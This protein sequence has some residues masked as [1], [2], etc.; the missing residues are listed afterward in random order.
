MEIPGVGPKIAQSIVAYFQD[1]GN[2]RSIE[3]LRGAGIRLEEEGAPRRERELPLAGRRF[4]VTGRLEGFSRTQAEAR[5]K[6]LGGSV[7]SS[8][9]R[10][11]SYLVTGEDPG[12]KLEQAMK[13]GVT[14]L[15]EEE[16][17]QMVG[18]AT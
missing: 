15:Y 14:L 11:T 12:S 10:K 13:L 9:S 16:F 7:G 5:I 17:L 18:R 1:D 4:V 8:V 6:E 3:R 2:L